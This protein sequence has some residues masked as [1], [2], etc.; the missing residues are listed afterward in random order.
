MSPISIPG[1]VTLRQQS[2][3]FWTPADITTALW[4]DAE[5]ASSFTL[6][7]TSVDQWRDKS[8][9]SRHASASSTARPVYAS[10]GFNGKPTVQFDGVNDQ[11]DLVQ[12]AQAGGQNI[13]AVIDTADIG[14]TYRLFLNRTGASASN[15]AIYLGGSASY[16]PM[17]YWDGG[18]RSPWGVDIQRKAIF[19]W[20]FY[21]GSP[22]SAL[23]QVDGATAVTS[24]C[25]GT[26]LTS[27]SSICLAST[28]Q[29]DIDLSELIITPT[30][31]STATR[32]KIE[33]YLAHKWG[34]IANLPSDH[35]YK[36]GAP[37]T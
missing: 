34:L 29:P 33:G 24:T 18:D 3:D 35:P 6:D 10:T 36:T 17:V 7:G 12:F 25:N 31:P 32:Q 8:G 15:L 37:T 30:D 2:V 1:K 13:F 26:L 23:T 22:A 28:Q 14:T 20:S 16:R 4:L 19:R 21:T 9:N 27:W 5:D 11:L